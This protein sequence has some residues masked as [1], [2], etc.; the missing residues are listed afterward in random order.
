[1]SINAFNKTTV[2]KQM[3]GET[4]KKISARPDRIFDKEAY[5]RKINQYKIIPVF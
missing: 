1:M 4:T 5:I 3:F 2:K